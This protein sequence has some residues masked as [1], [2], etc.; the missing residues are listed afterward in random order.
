MVN[1][2][3]KESPKFDGTNFDNQKD[4]MK[5]HLLCMG[6][7]YWLPT[8]T[9]RII[10]DEDNLETY[11]KEQRGVFMC[12]IRERKEILSTLPESDYSHI[13]LLKT[14]HEIWKTLEANYEGDTHA[15]G[16]IAKF[17]LRIPRC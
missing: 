1:M 7:G 10:I 16:Q 13:K 2:F 14:S 11:T 8:K 9:S 12:N 5:T 6:P 17:V 3:R 15:K 4:K